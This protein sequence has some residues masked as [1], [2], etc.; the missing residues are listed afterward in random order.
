MGEILGLGTT[1]FPPLTGRDEDMGW[2][3][4]RAL[5]DPA[6]PEQY[7]QANQIFEST[8]GPTRRACTT[9]CR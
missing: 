7:R 4:K 6:L 9:I 8:A 3:L 2:I 5:Q 1:H